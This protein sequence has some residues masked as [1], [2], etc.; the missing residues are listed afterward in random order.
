MSLF[1]LLI[2]LLVVA[3]AGGLWSNSGGRTFG[4]YG[5]SPLGIVLLILFVLFI[6]GTLDDGHRHGFYLRR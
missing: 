4:F 2:V 6:T 1:T 3:A 5:W